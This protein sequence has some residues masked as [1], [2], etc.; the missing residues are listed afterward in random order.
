MKESYERTSLM[1]TEFEHEDLIATSGESTRLFSRDE[2]EGHVID[3]D[4]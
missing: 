3:V 1:V 2:Y 4:R